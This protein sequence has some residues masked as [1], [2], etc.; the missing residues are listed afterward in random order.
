MAGFALTRA[1]LLSFL[2]AVGRGGSS[3]KCLVG[4]M[5]GL[6]PIFNM[7]FEFVKVDSFKIGEFGVVINQIRTMNGIYDLVYEPLFD[8]IDAMSGSLCV[9]D[10]DHV[11][12]NYL[13]GNGV[14]LDIHDE[15]VMLANGA[16]ADKGQYVGQI[17]FSF[18]TLKTMGWMKNIGG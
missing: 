18:E 7:G 12:F 9:V 15:T 5:R 2:G 16:L 6:A 1:E 8:E 10:F 11:Q 14:N 4:G 17:G 13:S 3:R